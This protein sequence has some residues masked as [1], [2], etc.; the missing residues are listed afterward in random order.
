MKITY[1]PK[2][3]DDLR[4]FRK[5]YRQ[6]FPAGNKNGAARYLA[7]IRALQENPSL[8]KPASGKSRLL[9][10]PR[11]PFSV[12]YFVRDGDICITRV[13]DNRSAPLDE[14][15]DEALHGSQ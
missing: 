2:A 14:G 15:V 10:V 8:G 9:A 1:L 5:Y 13:F 7:C 12:I 3:L 4:W 11:T 6:V